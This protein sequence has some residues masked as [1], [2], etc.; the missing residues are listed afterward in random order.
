MRHHSAGG[1]ARTFGDAQRAMDSF[2]EKGLVPFKFN[3]LTQQQRALIDGPAA[4]FFEAEASGD[5]GAQELAA[6]N[7]RQRLRQIGQEL[8]KPVKF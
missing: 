6:N 8:K 7:L 2:H 4:R 5:A 1:A 3:E